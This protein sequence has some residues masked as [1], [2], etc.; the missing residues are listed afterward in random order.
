MS[1]I[2]REKINGELVSYEITTIHKREKNNV[3]FLSGMLNY[4]LIKANDP[5]ELL[6]LFYFTE[7]LEDFE[8]LY[9]VHMNTISDDTKLFLL[10]HAYN[11][12]DDKLIKKYVVE[13]PLEQ[14]NKKLHE[15]DVNILERLC[16]HGLVV[17]GD[18]V[19]Y[20]QKL[21][22][23]HEDPEL[24]ELVEFILKHKPELISESCYS[25]ARCYK[26]DQIVKLLNNY[27]LES[28]ESSEPLCYICSSPSEPDRIITDICKCRM[29]I[30]YHCAQELIMRSDDEKCRTCDSFYKRNMKLNHIN[31]RGPVESNL[32]YFP[33][34]GIFP[35][36]LFNKKYQRVNK[37]GELYLSII[38]LQYKHIIDLFNSITLNE[39]IDL[40]Q[41]LREKL[42]DPC[43]GFGRVKD[44]KFVMISNTCSNAP[45][46]LNQMAYML[47]EISINK[48][49]M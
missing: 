15:Y 26:N 10:N 23:P 8:F 18:K 38:Y 36:P 44:N 3:F 25:T 41:K 42:S 21:R 13:L 5:D 19:S 47:T 34:L 17:S 40:K 48:L 35:V 49:F 33:H 11:L 14:L 43:N 28:S 24:L 31:I 1:L 2:L 37:F 9:M 6:K 30:H 7:Y 29:A 45:R 46:D 20:S 27:N 16:M 39:L 32:V 12:R 4:E 22:Y